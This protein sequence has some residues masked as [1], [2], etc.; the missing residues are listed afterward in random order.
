LFSAISLGCLGNLD[1][2][3]QRHHAERLVA[4]TLHDQEVGAVEPFVE[5]AKTIGATLDLD[6]AINARQRHG[7]VG[8]GIA[9]S[10][11]LSSEV[12]ITALIRIVNRPWSEDRRREGELSEK[13]R[14]EE[15]HRREAEF[16]RKQGRPRTE[17]KGEWP[18]AKE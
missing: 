8:P 5:F 4:I 13:E 14:E 2:K 3:P 16:L 10:R 15:F 6:V 17:H 9:R 12:E 11:T 1:G 18:K 7:Q